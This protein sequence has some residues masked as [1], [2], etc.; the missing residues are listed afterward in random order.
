VKVQ[1]TIS[2]E[3]VLLEIISKNGRF[4]VSNYNTEYVIMDYIREQAAELARVLG[5]QYVEKK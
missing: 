2:P 1:I 4:M 5:C 3:I